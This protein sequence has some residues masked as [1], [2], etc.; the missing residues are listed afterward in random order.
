MRR[1]LIAVVLALTPVLVTDPAA[2]GQ[3]IDRQILLRV[4]LATDARQ[5]AGCQRLGIVSDTS[6]E[7]LRK[8]ILRMGGDAGF[9]TFDLADPDRMNAEVY[10]CRQVAAPA[11]PPGLAGAD[12]TTIH[13]M[14]LGTWS[15]TLSAPPLGTGTAASPATQLPATVRMWDEG[16]QLRWAM[17]VGQDL[18]ASGTVTHFFGDVTLAGTYG[19]RA[20]P[21]TYSLRLSGPTLQGSGAGPDQVVRTLSL[22]K[23]P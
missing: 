12:P 4:L 22:R 3:P 11:T 20:Q 18:Q 9:V 21:I 1:A 16:G 5:V 17:E 8:K 19:E 14:L 15:G 7:D 6:P 13:R 23:Q 2:W 10:R